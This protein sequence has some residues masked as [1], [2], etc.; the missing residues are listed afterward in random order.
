MCSKIS[1]KIICFVCV[2][3]LSKINAQ[4]HKTKASLS[5]FFTSLEKNNFSDALVFIKN[6][7]TLCEQELLI[8]LHSSLLPNK[9]IKTYED[10]CK[11]AVS[12]IILHLIKGY[13]LSNNELNKRKSYIELTE[14]Y[15]KSKIYN[16]R[17]LLKFTT[18]SILQFYKNGILHN[19]EKFTKYL[20]DYFLMCTSNSDFLNYYSFSFN[21]K[22]QSKLKGGSNTKEIK[23]RY[24][25]IFKSYDSVAR[26]TKSD[27]L[28]LSKYFFDK[29]NYSILLNHPKEAKTNNKNSFNSIKTQKSTFFKTHKFNL[30]VQLC[31]INILEKNYRK[32]LHKITDAKQ[33][34]NYLSPTKTG[35]IINTYYSLCYANLKKYDSAYFYGNKA[36]KYEYKLSFIKNNE[37]ITEL[38]VEN[39]KMDREKQLLIE[40]YKKNY[41]GNLFIISL[42]LL[43]FVATTSILV[44]NNSKRKRKLAEQQKAI[45]TQKYL[46]L[47][48]EQEINAINAMI[49]GQEK[50]RKRIA[51]DLHDNIGSVLA[52]LKLHFE[53][54]KLNREKKHFNQEELY[55]KTEKLID[56]TYLKVRSIAHAKN[57][58][59]IA[60]KGLLSAIKIMAE[61]ISSANKLH[62]EVIDF[63]LNKRLDNS[64]EIAIFRIIQELITNILKH[65]DAKNASINLSV[66]NDTLNLIIEDDGKGFDIKKVNLKNGMGLGSIKTRIKHLKGTFEIDSSLNH[67]TSVLIDIPINT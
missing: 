39:E 47:L 25:T 4:K 16:Q 30:L 34:K 58:G 63:G 9:K 22:A 13:S 60:N 49:D 44:L 32:A 12:E 7:T 61:K 57:A 27:N 10:N 26:L 6:N 62:I 41:N 64:L 59:V 38:E 29:A 55:N 14:A 28:L 5:H 65:A 18:Y 3:N 66:Y 33:Y 42:S 15:K 40:K 50:E 43:I 8:E 36:K 21:L 24:K 45:E 20:S 17:T 31:R 23:Q 19:N 48:K 37:I 52:T 1:I 2:F 56:E 46:S 53:N 67:G 51:E 54:L 35:F 11:T